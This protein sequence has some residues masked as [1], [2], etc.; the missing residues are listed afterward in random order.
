MGEQ[1]GDAN[2]VVRTTGAEA[3]IPGVDAVDLSGR[4]TV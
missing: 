4:H 1:A 3:G 2:D